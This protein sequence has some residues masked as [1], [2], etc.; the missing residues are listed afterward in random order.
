MNNCRRYALP[1][2]LNRPRVVLP[3][4]EFCRGTRPSL[5]PARA[6]DVDCWRC[7]DGKDRR[8]AHT[9]FGLYACWHR[10]V[11][12]GVVLYV[13][14]FLDPASTA[15]PKVY[16]RNVSSPDNCALSLPPIQQCLKFLISY[17]ARWRATK[18]FTSSRPLKMTATRS[19]TTRGFF[20][21]W[22]GPENIYGEF[23]SGWYTILTSTISIKI[24]PANAPIKYTAES[25]AG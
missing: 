3:P 19:A 9:D 10:A 18:I 12:A 24:L 16:D 1:R 17:C 7:Q 6:Q 13:A 11:P 14:T 5:C 8:R 4:V 21:G 2:L 20:N 23:S 25:P 15:T 22:I